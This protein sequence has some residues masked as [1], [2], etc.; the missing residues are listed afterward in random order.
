MTIIVARIIWLYDMRLQPGSR[1]G[2]GYAGL[3]HGRHRQGEFQTYDMFTSTH[4]GPMVEF[5]AAKHHVNATV[6]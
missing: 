3:G 2:E 1:L 5:R 6:L 4:E